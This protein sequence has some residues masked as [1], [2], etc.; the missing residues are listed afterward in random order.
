M[1]Y[2]KCFAAI[3]IVAIAGCSVLGIVF[4]VRNNLKVG[5]D[6]TVTS[7]STEET[8]QLV[9]ESQGDNPVTVWLI[10][11]LW[12]GYR[13]SKYQ[14]RFEDS[15]Q[16]KGFELKTLHTSGHAAVDDIKRLIDSLEPIKVVP[17]HSMAPKSFLNI[18]GKTLLVKDRELITI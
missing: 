11:S 12:E 13:E 6:L 17:I 15:L 8:T 7:V 4:V 10:Y 2:K 16:L 1:N 3:A 5:I 9:A 18:T 14:Q